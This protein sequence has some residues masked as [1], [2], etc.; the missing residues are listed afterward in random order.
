MIDSKVTVEIHI[1]EED[2][3]YFCE[4]KNENGELKVNKFGEFIIDV[5]NNFDSSERKAKVFME[6]GGTFISVTAIYF[7]LGQKAKLT[8]L[9]E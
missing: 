1:S 2:N 3:A 7:K 6:F 5:G 4:E 9:F 8:C